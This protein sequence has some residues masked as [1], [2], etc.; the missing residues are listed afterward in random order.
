MSFRLTF[1]YKGDGTY[2]KKFF[3]G[4]LGGKNCPQKRIIYLLLALNISCDLFGFLRNYNYFI[5]NIFVRNPKCKN[6]ETWV[7]YNHSSH[8]NGSLVFE[9]WS[10]SAPYP[11]FFEIGWNVFVHA[12]FSKNQGNL[13]LKSDCWIGILLILGDISS[14]ITSSSHVF[15]NSKSTNFT[16]FSLL[17]FLSVFVIYI[18]S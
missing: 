18:N 6:Q 9:L 15:S 2:S 17:S 14:S 8:L 3:K 1:I 13:D 16:K 11:P 12:N 7:P 5:A 10:K 4:G